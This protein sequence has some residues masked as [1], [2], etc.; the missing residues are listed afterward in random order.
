[1]N[2]NTI[3]KT[4]K[5][6]GK[7]K[8]CYLMQ[9]IS[10]AI[11]YSKDSKKHYIVYFNA[12]PNNFK[13]AVVSTFNVKF[14]PKLFLSDG[15][16][17]IFEFL[18]D[19]SKYRLTNSNDFISIK[20]RI[21]RLLGFTKNLQPSKLYKKIVDD[22][23]KANVDNIKISASLFKTIKN[24]ISIKDNS[25]YPYAF[26]HDGKVTAN[27]FLTYKDLWIYL[28][29]E[30]IGPEVKIYDMVLHDETYNIMDICIA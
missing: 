27:T 9:H 21:L 18:D 3:Q 29:I 7:F 1:M 28:D 2:H 10:A 6:I 16:V 8:L 17:L 20:S 4:I 11:V 19:I 22:L 24:N 23:Q 26:T 12:D 30:N 14:L 5:L 15:D 25:F 13:N